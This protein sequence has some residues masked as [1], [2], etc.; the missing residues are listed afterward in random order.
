M[1]LLSASFSLLSISKDAS[2]DLSSP[3]FPTLVVDGAH[4]LK[5]ANAQQL[6]VQS[7]GQEVPIQDST[8]GNYLHL[9]N[10]VDIC[11]DGKWDQPA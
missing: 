5:S 4:I 6:V 3:K 8:D 7:S 11:C 9:N 10:A 1:S 2:T